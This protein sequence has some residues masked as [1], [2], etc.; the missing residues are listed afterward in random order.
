MARTRHHGKR[1]R[2]QRERDG[3]VSLVLDLR[4]VARVD[5]A[6]VQDAGR[7][8][9]KVRRAA[10]RLRRMAEAGDDRRAARLARR[11]AKG[12]R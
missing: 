9:R 4:D 12:G 6:G 8:L 3:A 1:A 2:L 7:T 11:M 5:G 10:K